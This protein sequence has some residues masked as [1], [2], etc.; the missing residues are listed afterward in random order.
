MAHGVV[1]SIQ[2]HRSIALTYISCEFV[3]HIPSASLEHCPR[4]SRPLNEIIT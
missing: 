4:G 2:E 3:N 1:L